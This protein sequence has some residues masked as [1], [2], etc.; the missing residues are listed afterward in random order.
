MILCEVEGCTRAGVHSGICNPHYQRKRRNG[1]MSKP[2]RNLDVSEK[3][4]FIQATAHTEH[5][6][7]V[8]WP[9]SIGGNGIP[10]TWDG[11]RKRTV[12]HLVLEAAGR[13]RPQPPLDNALHSC[14]RPICVSI[15]HLR[16][17]TKAENLQEAYDRGRRG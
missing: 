10:L 13:V 6:E 9:W 2:L 3:M 11:S 4:A 8:D 5:E 12:A 14:D 17:G 1:D 16:W 7:C 15:R